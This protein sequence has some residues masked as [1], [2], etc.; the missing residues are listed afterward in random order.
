MIG[1][2][3]RA[4]GLVRDGRDP[5]VEL[6]RQARQDDRWCGPEIVGDEAE[7]AEGTELEGDAEPVAV[8]AP[9]ADVREVCR[10]EGVA[11]RVAA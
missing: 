1:A 2:R 3:L 9:L 7:V 10:I 5:H 6:G 4:V 11:T 8:A